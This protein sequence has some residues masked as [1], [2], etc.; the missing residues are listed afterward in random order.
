MLLRTMKSVQLRGCGIGNDDWG[1]L[2]GFPTL[3][4]GRGVE[5]TTKDIQLCLWGT[6][7]ACYRHKRCGLRLRLLLVGYQRHNFKGHLVLGVCT[8]L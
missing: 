3:S 8:R 1:V 5:K 2:V 7:G 4:N 6:G